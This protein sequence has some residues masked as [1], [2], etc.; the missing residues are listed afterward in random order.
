MSG[1]IPRE[2]VG[3]ASKGTVVQFLKESL[4]ISYKSSPKRLSVG[5]L[6]IFSRVIEAGNLEMPE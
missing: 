4:D 5:I 3:G 2:T 6:R 1:N